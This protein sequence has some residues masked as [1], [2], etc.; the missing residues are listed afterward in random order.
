VPSKQEVSMHF[1]RPST[2]DT[3]LRGIRHVAAASHLVAVREVRC[4]NIQRAANPSLAVS[5]CRAA[6][7]GGYE[8][9]SPM[10]GSLV[11]PVRKS[12]A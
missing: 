11:P 12:L 10:P 3:Q 8:C 9:S 7:P 6:F 1:T 5:P 4:R 2:P